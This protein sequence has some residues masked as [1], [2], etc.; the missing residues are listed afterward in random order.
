MARS[1]ISEPL[2]L[3]R[4]IGDVVDSFTPSIKMGITF[5]NKHVLNG[6]QFFPSSLS[7]KPRVHVSGEDMRSL[8]TL[9]MV[10][11]DVPGPSDPFLREHL[12]WLVTDIPGTTDATFGRE[13]VSYEIPKPTIGIHRFVFVLFKQKHR[14]S[15]NSPSSRDHFNTRRFA[16]E[17]DLGLPVAA[18]YFNAQRGTAASSRR[19]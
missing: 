2:V 4:V 8:F 7:F 10:D 18:V 15:V 1:K 6:Y 12:H 16:A 11:P 5:S 17:N 14:C 13:E 19:S 9:I 3:G